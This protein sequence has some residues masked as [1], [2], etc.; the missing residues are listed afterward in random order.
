M[1]IHDRRG[2]KDNAQRM[3]SGA[4]YDPGKL[5]LIYNGIA[6]LVM[7]V[8]SVLNYILALQVEDTGGLSGLAMRSMLETAA[9]VLQLAG[10]LVMPFWTMGYV[11]AILAIARGQRVGPETL[12]TGFRR[13]GPV[14]RLVFLQAVIYLCLAILCINISTT[15]FML[16]PMSAPLEEILLADPELLDDATLVAAYNAMIPLLVIFCV[17]YAAVCV[18]ISYR[19]RMADYALL[20]DPRMGAMGALRRSTRLM[21]GNAMALVRLDLSFWWFYGL[22]AVL[23]ALCYGDVILGALGVQL[24]ISADAAYFVFYVLYLAGQM[25]LYLWR[26]NQV[27]TTYA[28]AYC[29]LD[30]KVE[31]PQPLQNVPYENQ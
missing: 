6:V 22:E 29:G 3:L 2:L 27:E 7:L 28:L 26:R 25:V 1:D 21:R 13:F 31:K 10:N 18:P 12:L 17:V 19:F 30:A 9:S 4:S 23:L 8:I 15:I 14:M 16:T 20:D 24:P 11:A 5:M